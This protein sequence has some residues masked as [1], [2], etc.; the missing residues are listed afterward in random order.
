MSIWQLFEKAQANSTSIILKLKA[1]KDIPTYTLLEEFRQ[2][3]LE[4]EDMHGG[5][6]R[7]IYMINKYNFRFRLS[8]ESVVK[9]MLLS[10]PWQHEV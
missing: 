6:Q 2:T 8:R 5:P 1:I 3:T 9:M 7:V 10:L 4:L